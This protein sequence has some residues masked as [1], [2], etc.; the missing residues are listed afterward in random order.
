MY[1]L[2]TNVVA[3]L[4]K[5]KSR[6]MDQKVLAWARSV[7]A[8]RLYLSVITVLELELGTLLV[9]RRDPNRVRCFDP[10]SMPMF[11]RHSGTGFC[12][13]IQRSDNVAPDFMFPTR[14]RTG[15]R[16]SRP[17]HWCME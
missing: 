13:L 7:P 16:S 15:M 14:V 1:L 3:E 17:R 10:G 12:L 6:K 11:C 2:D 4:R 5:A 9:E 8:A